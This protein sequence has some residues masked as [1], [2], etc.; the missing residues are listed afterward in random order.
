MQSTRGILTVT[1]ICVIAA[2][3]VPTAAVTLDQDPASND[4]VLEPTSQY[5]ATTNGELE[6]DFEALNERAITTADDVFTITITSADVERVWISND[7]DGLTFYKGGDPSAEVDTASPLEPSA[8][9]AASIGVAI[10][11]HLVQSGTET[12]TVHVAYE[13]ELPN[14]DEG[15][16]D[17]DEREKKGNDTERDAGTPLEQTALDATPTTVA[18]G[19]PVTVTAT[20]E[21]VG[22]ETGERTVR[23]TADGVLADAESIALEPNETATVTFEWNADAAGTYDLAVDD[24]SAGTITVEE[25]SPAVFSLDPRELP[26]TTTAALAPPTALG[27]LSLA[28]IVT[29]RWQ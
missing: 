24:V 28:S 27:L 10:D 20:Y 23:L 11:T 12:F 7:V 1:A 6:L 18:T 26:A 29:R 9:E 3:A 25:P 22:D 2:L 21:N 13:D 19:E 8:S 5:A 17:R 4:V 14:D 16:D 15:D